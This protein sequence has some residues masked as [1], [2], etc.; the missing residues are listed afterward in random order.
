MRGRAAVYYNDI[1]AGLLTALDE[2]YIFSYDERYFADPLLPA[3]SISFPKSVK[4]YH[5]SILFPFFFGLLAE[6]DQKQIQ[7]IRLGIDE[8]DHFTR[9]IKTAQN[10]IGAISV[11]E[12]PNE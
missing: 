2:G 5:S 7:C 9:L 11:K 3:I 8:E 1:L 10:T 12:V 4:E 6:G